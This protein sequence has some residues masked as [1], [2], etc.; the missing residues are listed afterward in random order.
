[1]VFRSDVCPGGDLCATSCP[2]ALGRDRY[3][4][5]MSLYR[6]CT[7]LVYSSEVVILYTVQEPLM[8]VGMNVV[9]SLAIP[10]HQRI[11]PVALKVVVRS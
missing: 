3:A 5:W 7:C 1:M 6:K 10:T 9:L 11:L 8:H 2:T 4:V